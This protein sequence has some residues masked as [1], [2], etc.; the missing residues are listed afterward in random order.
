MA[1][2]YQAVLYDM[3]D[4]TIW[5]LAGRQ[6]EEGESGSKIVWYSQCMKCFVGLVVFNV[7]L[8]VIAPFRHS[9]MIENTRFD[10][11]PVDLHLLPSHLLL[12]WV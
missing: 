12:C 8:S 4:M 7:W 3:I 11:N 9:Q 1:T 6:Q 5:V 10:V 2:P